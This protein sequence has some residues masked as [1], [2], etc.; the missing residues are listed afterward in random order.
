MRKCPYCGE[1]FDEALSYCPS[2]GATY[3]EEAVRQAYTARMNIENEKKQKAERK[4]MLFYALLGVLCVVSVFVY[5]KLNKGIIS[6]NVANGVLYVEDKMLSR[7]P[8]EI[9]IKQGT[10]KVKIVSG[11]DYWKGNVVVTAR[12]MCKPVGDLTV[13]PKQEITAKK[14][15]DKAT[16]GDAV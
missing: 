11:N 4:R 16:G 6:I 2:C 13:L 14:A 5:Q 9:S 15:K 1:M 10:Y 12:Q 7:T 3:S 8:C